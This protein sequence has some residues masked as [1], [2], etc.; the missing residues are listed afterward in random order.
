MAG[1]ATL[2]DSYARPED[3]F[4]KE[5]KSRD[6]MLARVPRPD[7]VDLPWSDAISQWYG[8]LADNNGV[9]AFDTHVPPSPMVHGIDLMALVQRVSS[10][11]ANNA[12]LVNANRIMADGL[13]SAKWRFKL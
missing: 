2:G 7:G 1:L 10:L 13:V 9:V 4:R 5:E 11:E 3:S 12:A 8:E 6:L